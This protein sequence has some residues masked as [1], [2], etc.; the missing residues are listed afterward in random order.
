MA[1]SPLGISKYIALVLRFLLT[2]ICEMEDL[3]TQIWNSVVLRCFWCSHP[4]IIFAVQTFHSDHRSI[5]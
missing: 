2:E 5:H 4:L 1:E 3:S